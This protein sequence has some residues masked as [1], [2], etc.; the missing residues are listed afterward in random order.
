MYNNY[1]G[2]VANVL[3]Q[4]NKIG[5]KFAVAQALMNTYQ[6]ISNVWSEKSELGLVGAGFAQRLATTALVASQG[7]ATVKN[8]M[9]TNPTGGA[10]M[11]MGGGGGGAPQPA[12]NVV[13]TSG[14][15][16]IAEQLS[17][18]QEPVQAFVVGS[19]VTTQQ[20]MDRNIVT[21]ASLG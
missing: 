13:G 21:T 17:Q 16:Q 14:V 12:F 19:N 10:S 9:K 1:F 3:G 15:N 18:E 5:K 11:S 20:E 8:I 2:A 6:G 4:Q 7:F